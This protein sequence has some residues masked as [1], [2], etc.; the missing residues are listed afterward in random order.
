MPPRRDAGLLFSL[1]GDHRP[2]RHR[3]LG[4]FT[5]STSFL[6]VAVTLESSA[7]TG[8]PRSQGPHSVLLS[9]GRFIEPG[10]PSRIANGPPSENDRDSLGCEHG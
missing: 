4:S 1:H 5:T 2:L 6:D 9:P 3:R 10:H 7:S 8:P